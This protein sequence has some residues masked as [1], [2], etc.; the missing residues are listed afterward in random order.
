MLGS[1]SGEQEL[2]GGSRADGVGSAV[3]GDGVIRGISGHGSLDLGGGGRGVGLQVDGSSSA[4]VGG[5]HGG[6]RDGQS[7]SVG[8]DPSRGDGSTRGEDVN[9]LSVVGESGARVRLISED[10]RSDGSGSSRDGFRGRGGGVQAGIVV[11]V[12]SSD[13][14]DDSSFNQVG[15]GGVNTS[16]ETTSQRQVGN[17]WATAGSLLGGS[18][19]DSVDDSSERSR[20]E[21][22]QDLNGDDRRVLGNTIDVTSN[23]TSNVS[24]VSIAIL[25]GGISEVGSPGGARGSSVAEFV[26]SDQNSSVNDVSINSQTGVIVIVFTVEFNGAFRDTVDSPG[27]STLDNALTSLVLVDILIGFERSQQRVILQGNSADGGHFDGKSVEVLEVPFGKDGGAGSSGLG[28]L[29]R[30]TLSIGRLR[31]EDSNVSVGD[32]TNG[33]LGASN[34]DGGEGNEGQKGKGGNTLHST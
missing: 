32:D 12:T 30:L 10:V 27:G 4:D 13:G 6:T 9:A 19:V 23:S 15:D 11:I 8:T 26:V 21:A 20:S 29:E 16:V 17:R 22:V 33:V 14:S 3:E 25:V 5:G 18:P 7:G 2:V 28:V 24:T 31:L 34:D 1:A